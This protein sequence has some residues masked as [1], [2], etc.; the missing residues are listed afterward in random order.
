MGR[1]FD[2]DDAVIDDYDDDDKDD[3]YDDDNEDVDYDVIHV[4][5]DY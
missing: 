5:D 1:I 4:L 2:N 3:N